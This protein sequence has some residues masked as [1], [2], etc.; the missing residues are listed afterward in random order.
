MGD[1]NR[2]KEVLTAEAGLAF[3]F[4]EPVP[5]LGPTVVRLVEIIGQMEGV[6]HQLRARVHILK[7]TIDGLT[8]TA[9]RLARKAGMEEEVNSQVAQL[10]EELKEVEDLLLEV[11]KVAAVIAVIIALF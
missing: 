5:S 7:R 11:V 6:I 8:T 1:K 3:G 9:L 4:E 10:T 2:A